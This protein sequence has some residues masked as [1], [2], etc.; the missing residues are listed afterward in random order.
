MNNKEK[1]LETLR[2]MGFDLKEV[3][4]DSY[5]FSYEDTNILYTPFE[6]DENFLHLAI[7]FIFGVTDEN[8]EAVLE[9]IH[10]TSLFIK[11]S[12]INIMYQSTVWAVYE[13]YLYTTDNLEE[14]LEHIIK[15]LLLT[16]VTFYKK[17]NG[18]EIEF[19]QPNSEGDA[20][21]EPFGLL[22]DILESDDEED[23]NIN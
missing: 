18:E 15:L 19:T 9:A 14:L 6:E 10:D 17:I 1:V 2:S 8:R 22:D 11:Y 13:H 3:G 23:N 5:M 20:D 4:N 12:K 21:D 16:V 7:P